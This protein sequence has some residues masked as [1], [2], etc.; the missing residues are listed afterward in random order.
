MATNPRVPVGGEMV[1]RRHHPD[2]GDLV[3]GLTRM[4]VCEQI[5]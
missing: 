3:L 1:V 5:T 2:G 4:T